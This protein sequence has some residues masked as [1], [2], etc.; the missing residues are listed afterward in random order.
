MPFLER[1]DGCKIYYE[2][3]GEGI[4]VLFVAPGGMTSQIGNWWQWCAAALAAAS[5]TPPLI[6]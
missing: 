6:N 4:P 2:V 3:R 1:P 5:A